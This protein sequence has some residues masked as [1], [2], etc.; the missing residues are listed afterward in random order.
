MKCLVIHPEDQTTTFLRPIYAPL[1][2]KTVISGDISKSELQGLIDAH[3]QVIMLGHGS[4]MGLLSVGRF[5]DTGPY[6][7]D[8]SMV[9]SLKRKT[10]TIYIW[11]NADQFVQRHGLSGLFSG[12]Y[13]SEIEES[14]FFDFWDVDWKM[15]NESNDVFSSILSQHINQ[16]IDVL[17]EKLKYGYGL[18]KH[19]NPIAKYNHDRLYLK[20][21][22][23]HLMEN[24]WKD[25]ARI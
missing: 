10:N 15:I 17:Y 4:P 13:I 22:N 2:N 9:N 8:D 20:M 3:E 12:M 23:P 18:L 24:P 6:I 25:G 16:P 7:I 1:K 5:P 19:S 14:L 21:P 11:C